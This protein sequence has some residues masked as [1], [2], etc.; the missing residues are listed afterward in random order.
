ME[1]VSTL[2]TKGLPSRESHIEVIGRLGRF[3]QH[4]WGRDIQVEGPTSMD[5]GHL[6]LGT[7]K[8]PEEAGERGESRSHRTL[9]DL[10]N[11]KSIG[12]L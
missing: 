1:S 5:P 10:E 11:S 9:W 12:S 7:G 8:R 4:G 2:E 6:A 3:S